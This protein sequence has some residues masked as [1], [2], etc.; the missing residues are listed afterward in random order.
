[1]NVLVRENDGGASP[2][3][4]FLAY[5]DGVHHPTGNW[6]GIA[7]GSDGKSL[8]S[9]A[10]GCLLERND[11]N[12][13]FDRRTSGFGP[14]DFNY[15]IVRQYKLVG[16]DDNTAKGFTDMPSHVTSGMDGRATL[17]K[18]GFTASKAI[19]DPTV[20]QFYPNQTCSY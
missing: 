19:N 13:I 4:G 1:V 7:V 9:A 18:G 3:S 16:A 11:V 17:T 8:C 5:L 6:L 10:T 20:S 14:G 15:L 12:S 2:G